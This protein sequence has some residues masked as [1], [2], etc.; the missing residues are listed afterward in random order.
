MAITTLPFSGFYNSY[1]DAELDSTLEQMFSDRE[2]GCQRNTDLENYMSDS[3]DWRQV[4]TEYAKAY[5]VAFG[6]EFKIEG[7]EFESLSCPKEYNFSTDRIFAVVPDSELARILAAVEPVAF[8]ALIR[9]RFTSC[10]G[11]ISS[12]SNDLD[13][14]G[15]IEEWD[16]NQLGT[17]V[18]AYANQETNAGGFDGLAELSLMESAQTNGRLDSWISEATPEAT[19]L[20]NIHDYLNAR[21]ERDQ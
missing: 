15:P 9:A 5:A 16:H 7:L 18:W 12:Y 14:W 21:K 4:H 2:T 20:F 13:D 11:F 3:C 6:S 8:R 17:L 10:D 19:R 1:H